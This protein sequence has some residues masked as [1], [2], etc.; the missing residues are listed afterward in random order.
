MN[1]VVL[2]LDPL[3]SDL[4]EVAEKVAA[5]LPIPPDKVLRLL[6]R[7]PGPVTRAVPERDARKVQSVMR[8]AGLVVEVREGSATGA[9]VELEAA[10]TSTWAGQEAPAAEG[11]APASLAEAETL[12]EPRTPGLPEEADAAAPFAASAGAVAA[13]PVAPGASVTSTESRDPRRTESRARTVPPA[14]QTTTNPPRHPAF[15]TLERNP[16]TLERTGLRRRI[17]SAATMPALLTLVVT[18]LAVAVT[19][20]P[21]LR[22]EE[23]R[24]VAGVADAVAATVEGLSG[25]LPLSA[26]IIRMEL[27]AVET[28]GAATLPGRGVDFLLLVDGDQVPVLAWYRG[29]PGIDAFPEA[30]RVAALDRAKAALVGSAVGEETVASDWFGNVAASGRDL[31]ALVGLGS[32]ESTLAAAPVHRQG[33]VSAVLVAGAEPSGLRQFGTALLAALLVGLVPVLFGVLAVLSLTRG[34]RQSINYLLV[35]TDR[36]SHGDFD[37]PVEL[38]RDDELGQIAGA[39]ERMR[40]SLREGME[41]LRQR[42]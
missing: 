32:L 27:D 28:R 26:P 25:G 37:Q 33:A 34:L 41:R 12:G 30:V 4:P 40:I 8:A 15:T 31:M 11:E 7:A 10:A 21:I 14:G 9:V 13:E 16:P 22:Q 19:V 20:L 6:E 2:V 29:R 5:G 42:R 39:V 23:Q 18:V 24:R 3:P 17:T 36:I 38:E 1:Y 35:A